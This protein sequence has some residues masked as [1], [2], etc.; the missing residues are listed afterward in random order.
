M[1]IAPNA[2][3]SLIMGNTSP[4]IEPY[5]ANVFRQ[6]TMS[7]AHVYKNRFLRHELEKL[8]MDT[9]EVWANIIANDGSVQHLDIP[10]DVK[11][12]FKTAVELDQRWIIDLA[13]DRQEYVDQG[14]S[15]NLFFR[16]D[17]S[18][19]YLHAIHFLAWKMGLKSLYYCRS[20]KLR[21][22]DKVGTR[23]ERK[24]IEDEVDLSAVAD[25]DVCVACEG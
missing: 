4:S 9:D 21:K 19:K 5:R 8:G 16:P 22:A 1:A 3:S 13:A 14:Q 24:R 23:I 25:G 7:G 12:V 15:V 18:V 17:V 10:E 11:A 6:D 20:D 2:S